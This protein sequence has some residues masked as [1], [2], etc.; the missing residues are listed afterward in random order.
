MSDAQLMNTIREHLTI[1][2]QLPMLDARHP[3]GQNL[4]TVLGN[5]ETVCVPALQERLTS[6]PS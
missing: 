1:Q 6:R 4:N 3:E 2:K 5:Q